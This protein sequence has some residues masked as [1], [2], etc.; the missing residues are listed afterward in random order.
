[1]GMGSPGNSPVAVKLFWRADKTKPAVEI[2][3]ECLEYSDPVH[4]DS[5]DAT[6][7]RVG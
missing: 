7:A 3:L 4:A 6:Q 1:M 2:F 5:A